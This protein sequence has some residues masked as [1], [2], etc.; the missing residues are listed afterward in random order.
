M[1]LSEH[2]FSRPY[3]LWVFNECGGVRL[4][5]LFL[6]RYKINMFYN[7]LLNLQNA[8]AKSILLCLGEKYIVEIWIA[9]LW[10]STLF[11]FLY[12]VMLYNCVHVSVLFQIIVT[13]KPELGLGVCWVLLQ[14][15]AEHKN[16]GKATGISLKE[17]KISPNPN[18]FLYW[19]IAFPF[20]PAKKEVRFCVCYSYELVLFT[21]SQ[22]A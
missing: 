9:E 3:T 13:F 2:L 12:Q 10:L 1:Q 8:W 11:F 15:P 17:P 19:L 7:F 22:A 21:I 6:S 16:E 5:C 20:A 14:L 18:F 4:V